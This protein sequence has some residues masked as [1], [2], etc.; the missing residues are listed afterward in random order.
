VTDAPSPDAEPTG[1]EPPSGQHCRHVS[2][3]AVRAMLDL[4]KEIAVDGKVAVADV[5]RIAQAILSAGGPLGTVYYQ[6]TRTCED[7]FNRIA[8]ERQRRDPLGRLVVHPITDLLDTPTGIE[9]RR[10][11]QFLAAVRMM[12]GEEVHE[13]LRARATALATTHRGIDGMI[14]WDSFHADPEAVLILEQVLVGIAKSFT[15]FDARR[16]WFLVVLN[17]NPSAISTGSTSFVALKPE[18]RAQFA[19]TQG[20]M[21]RLFDAL[22]VSVHR[23]NFPSDRV[24]AFSRRWN[25]APE[26]LFGPLFL[27]VARLHQKGA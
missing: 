16:D 11:P 27:E 9:R 1:P 7:V 23:D 19:F 12:I 21:A 13:Q 3:V 4:I 26:K 8:I 18:E 25:V 20:H 6:Q 24:R 15:R 22:F 17:A 10:L 2:G 5:D 14:A